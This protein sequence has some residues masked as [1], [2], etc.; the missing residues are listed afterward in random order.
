ME[1]RSWSVIITSLH[2]PTPMLAWP[3]LSASSDASGTRSRKQ[4]MPR[5]RSMQLKSLSALDASGMPSKKSK[6]PRRVLKTIMIIIIV[7][8]IVMLIIIIYI[9]IYIYI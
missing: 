2:L 4:S 8:I 5:T 3:T 7:M 9:Y 1:S 6:V